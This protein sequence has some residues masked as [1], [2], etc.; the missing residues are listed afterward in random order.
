MADLSGTLIEAHGRVETATGE[1]I[2]LPDDT[3]QRI[4]YALTTLSI[5]LVIEH[6]NITAVYDAKGNHLWPP[7]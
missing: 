7:K 5:P 6:I 3:I 1:Q 2:A 4:V